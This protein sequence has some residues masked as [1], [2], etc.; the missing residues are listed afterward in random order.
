MADT[1][2]YYR[3]QTRSDPGSA[4]SAKVDLDGFRKARRYTDVIFEVKSK[5]IHAHRMILAAASPVFDIMFNAG[6]SESKSEIIKIYDTSHN[7]FSV[8]ID[9]IYGAKLD[10]D[11]PFLAMK[12]IRLYKYYQIKLDRDKSYDDMLAIVLKKAR[13]LP[14]AQQMLADTILYVFDGEYPSNYAS[15]FNS[16]LAELHTNNKDLDFSV[17]ADSVIKSYFSV[18]NY[19]YRPD[20]EMETFRIIHALV[21]SGRSDRLYRLVAY[22]S[23]SKYERERLPPEILIHNQGIKRRSIEKE[24]NLRRGCSGKNR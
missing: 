14:G 7:V 13:Y 22:D 16:L 10:Y 6:F 21:E 20:N 17:Y 15:E 11:E 8:F 24:Q 2:M 12:V 1:A 5:H 19:D 18:N 3:D 4:P 23:M 9:T